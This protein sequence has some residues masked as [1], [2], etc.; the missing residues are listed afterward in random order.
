VVANGCGERRPRGHGGVRADQVEVLVGRYRA[1]VEAAVAGA[2][3]HLTGS[4]LLGGFAGHDIDLVALVPHVAA[5]A[6][7]L[8]GSLVLIVYG[9]T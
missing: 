4:T 3:V 7:M 2:S 9:V 1:S 6:E 5:A 8:R